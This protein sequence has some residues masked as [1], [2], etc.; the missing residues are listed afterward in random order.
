MGSAVDV[1]LAYQLAYA[2]TAAHHAPELL[3]RVRGGDASALYALQILQ[4]GSPAAVARQP[5]IQTIAA[6]MV[7]AFA[8]R[9]LGELRECLAIGLEALA[10]AWLL[11]GDALG[12][13]EPPGHTELWLE[14]VAPLI[15]AIDART[16]DLLITP[17]P[18][19]PELMGVIH[20]DVPPFFRHGDLRIPLVQLL[21]N[22][23]APWTLP[24]LAQLPRLT[25]V[26]V[27]FA[28]E[29]GGPSS[30]A[31]PGVDP[32]SMP[33]LRMSTAAILHRLA[34][35]PVLRA[36]MWA[37]L[38]A[39]C[40]LTRTLLDA[41]A[42]EPERSLLLLEVLYELGGKVGD[43]DCATARLLDVDAARVLAHLLAGP[44]LAFAAGANGTDTSSHGKA[45]DILSALVAPAAPGADVRPNGHAVRRLWEGGVLVPVLMHVA[46]AS[47][48]HAAGAV[49][50]VVKMLADV[51]SLMY[52]GSDPHTRQMMA[53]ACSPSTPA[54]PALV[55][56]LKL[57]AAHDDSRE[58][59]R[60]LQPA[61]AHALHQRQ[62]A[63]ARSQPLLCRTELA[64]TADAGCMLRPMSAPSMLL[65]E[66]RKRMRTG[67]GCDAALPNSQ[68]ALAR[69][70]G[71]SKARQMR[72]MAWFRE[73]LH[74]VLC[75]AR[76]LGIPWPSAVILLDY[77]IADAHGNVPSF[78]VHSEQAMDALCA[79]L[80]QWIP[81][82][83]ADK[84]IAEMQDCL[85]RRRMA[86]R[87][88]VACAYVSRFTRSVLL[89]C[90]MLQLNEI[91]RRGGELAMLV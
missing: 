73:H 48:R 50:I 34:Q 81:P 25:R 31:L 70:A 23:V 16:R 84:L 41:P 72:M 63:V 32:S 8:R 39:L 29:C 7:D 28:A 47:A 35:S 83:K 22:V 71:S 90:F 9:T 57:L 30:L 67:A 77:E 45:L 69:G 88:Y 76:L 2:C 6:A 37:E 3:S 64:L 36:A 85:E 42:D 89:G 14:S 53:A 17:T 5:V 56:A 49:C 66:Q 51:L 1:E 75:S 21:C 54:T 33:T 86:T 59:A 4:L 40:V 65:G 38:D 43:K 13:R 79:A 55:H 74:V 87:D 24:T 60:V 80:G 82:N 91:K 19:A 11:A 26:L 46:S 52:Y 12:L 20:D 44:P 58:R 10:N 15:A 18:L 78:T 27:R 68:A 61:T 62:P